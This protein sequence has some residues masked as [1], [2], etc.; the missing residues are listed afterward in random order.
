MAILIRLFPIQSFCRGNGDDRPGKPDRVL[1]GG[2]TSDAGQAAVE[3][4]G[5][6]MPSGYRESGLLPPICGLPNFP[7]LPLMPF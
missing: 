4:V 6:F 5:R 3:K 2:E 1:I 7:N